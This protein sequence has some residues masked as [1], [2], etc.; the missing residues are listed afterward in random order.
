MN[1]NEVLEKAKN[2]PIPPRRVEKTEEEWKAL[3]TAEQYVIT[4]RHGTEMPFSGEYCEAYSPGIY[5]CICCG[6]ELFDSTVKFNSGTGW[7]SFTG[8]LADNIIKYESDGSFGMQRVEVLCNVCDAH[9]GHV[10]PDGPVPSG[11]RFCI[12]SA[13]LKK[14]EL[15]ET[16][17]KD[18]FS[19]TATLGSGCFWCTEAVLDELEGVT[20]VESGYSGGKTKDPTYVQISMGNTRHAEVVQVHFNPQMISY[21]DILRVFLATHDPTSLDRQGADVGSQY[22][23]IILFHNVAQEQ[24]AREIIGEMQ[25]SFDKPIVTEVVAFTKFYKAEESHQQFYRNNPESSYCRAVI[26]P[27]LQK[28]RKQFGETL[29]K[30]MQ[31]V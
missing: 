15:E 17:K 16:V 3:L 2:N 22:R 7:P 13:S 23:Y 30:K 25:P 21:A 29:K 6:T 11:L 12:N 19:E 31:K 8:P 28:L 18:E 26:N 20:K 27:K 9:L 14:I 5:S 24:T 1:W 10:F 4:R